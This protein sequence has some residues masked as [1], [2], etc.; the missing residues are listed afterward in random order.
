MAYWCPIPLYPVLLLPRYW[1]VDPEEPFPP[2]NSDYSDPGSALF[3][4]H[5]AL[6][7]MEKYGD[8]P[9]PGH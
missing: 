1:S 6:G 9:Q 2:A 3:Y 4:L 5:R 8:L 7:W